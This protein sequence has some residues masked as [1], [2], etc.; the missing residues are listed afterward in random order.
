VWWIIHRLKRWSLYKSRLSQDYRY[1]DRTIVHWIEPRILYAGVERGKCEVPSHREVQQRRSPYFNFL[2]IY[3]ILLFRIMREFQKPNTF[4]NCCLV[5][6]VLWHT[7][8]IE[9]RSFM[10]KEA[11]SSLG[12]G[13][14]VRLSRLFELWRWNTRT[15]RQKNQWTADNYTP[16]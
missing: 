4:L 9:L 12:C 1:L 2:T 3:F 10:L 11:N 5:L 14:V 15:L 16:T 6:C 7:C 13:I 8:N